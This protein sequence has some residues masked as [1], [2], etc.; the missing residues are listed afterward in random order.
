MRTIRCQLAAVLFA[1]STLLTP[2]WATSFSTDQSDLWYV[3]SESGWGMQLVQRAEVI[4]ATLFVYD[5]NVMPIWYVAT[6][7]PRTTDLVWSGDLYLTTGPWFGSYFDPTRVGY[8][9]VGTMKWYGT[10][11]EEGVVEYSVDGVEVAKTVVRQLLVY[12]DYNG[13]YV[14]A[15]RTTN[16][17]CFNPA[18]DGSDTSIATIRVIQSGQS[19]S[20]SFVR[21]T[22]TVTINGM[23]TQ[24]GQFG[25]V[26]GTFNTS[27]GDAGN[28]VLVEIN[29]Q[30]TFWTARFGA[31]SFSTGCQMIGYLGGIRQ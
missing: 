15:V 25:R 7:R 24:G 3:Q 27:A 23:L 2:V 28:F 11:I 9:K 31:T 10:L 30:H 29:G 17:G 22:E 1:I 16:T 14:G 19:V 13:T 18:N 4:F 8:R 6:L 21:G 12:D 5:S 20:V 26:D